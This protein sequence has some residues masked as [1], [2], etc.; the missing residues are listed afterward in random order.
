MR[1]YVRAIISAFLLVYL[2]PEAYASVKPEY[3]ASSIYNRQSESVVLIGAMRDKGGSSLG[4]GFI[5]TSDG[6][7]V[8]NLHIIHKSKKIAVRLKNKK[9]YNNVQILKIDPRKD[10]AIIKIDAKGLKPVSLG[11]SNQVKVGQKV[12]AIGNPIGLENTVSDGLVSSLRDTNEGFK[13]FQVS[14]PLSSG[15]SGGS[16]FNLKGEV[17]AITTAT[18]TQGQNINFALPI[19]C[20]KPLLKGYLPL[21][22]NGKSLKASGGKGE[23]LYYVVKPKDTLCGLAKRF[24]A[25]VEQ[26]S[27]W[28]NITGT[29]IYSG[30]KIKIIVRSK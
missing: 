27:D 13:V 12:V 24:G 28:N 23:V 20:A 29:T 26:I 6:V 19:N 8:T 1:L 15:S 3:S 4:S 14:V 17:I 18:N 30:Q 21:D 25:S 9:E 16:L 11:D 2:S 7:I 10:I 22:R 5:V